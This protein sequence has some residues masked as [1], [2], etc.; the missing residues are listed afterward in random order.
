MHPWIPPDPPSDSDSDT[1]LFHSS[2]VHNLLRSGGLHS[3]GILPRGNLITGTGAAGRTYSIR[4]LTGDICCCLLVALQNMLPCLLAEQT[5]VSLAQAGAGLVRA[6]TASKNQASS[7][8]PPRD[9][10]ARSLS[11]PLW[12]TA[13]LLRRKGKASQGGK[14]LWILLLLVDLAHS[15]PLRFVFLAVRWSDRMPLGPTTSSCR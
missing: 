11:S 5:R 1:L 6:S 2:N 13:R 7:A 3:Q 12:P 15:P 4:P 8:A 14:R 9:G 10:C